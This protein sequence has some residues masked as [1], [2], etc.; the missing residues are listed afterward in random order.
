[1]GGARARSQSRASLERGNV[2]EGMLCE[3]HSVTR[4]LWPSFRRPRA[5]LP[6]FFCQRGMAT[7]RARMFVGITRLPPRSSPLVGR[8]EQHFCDS[9]AG[10][11]YVRAL[12]TSGIAACGPVSAVREGIIHFLVLSLGETHRACAIVSMTPHTK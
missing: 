11:S 12:H 10:Q 4:R 5:A 3:C 1:M 2:R 9:A 6:P 7:L 8:R